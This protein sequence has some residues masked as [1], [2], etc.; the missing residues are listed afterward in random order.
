[1]KAEDWVRLGEHLKANADLLEAMALADET[2]ITPPERMT[3][4][5][6]WLMSKG[7]VEEDSDLLHLS[8]LLLDVGAQISIQGFDRVAPDLKEILISIEEG[9]EAYHGAKAA[10]DPAETERHLRRVTNT[11]RQVVQ[12]LRNEQNVTRAFIEGGYGF[13]VRLTDRIRDI[14]NA[15][16]RLKRLHEKLGLFTHTGLLQL[17]RSDRALRGKLIDGLLGAVSRNRFALDEMIGRLDRLSLTVRKRNKMRQVAQAV[18]AHLQGGGVIDLEPLLERLDAAVWAGAAPLSLGGNAFCDVHAGENLEQL[19][20]LIASLPAP[21]VKAASAAAAQER[22]SKIVPSGANQ[23]K[24]LEKPF[25]RAHLEA[26][27]RELIATGK[28]Q[29]A[30][31][32]WQDCGDPDIPDGIWLYALD[33]YAQLQAAFAKAN[34]KKLNY[35]LVLTMAPH[36]RFSANR[37][38]L[39]LTLDRVLRR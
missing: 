20:L 29:S 5:L 22:E 12:H 32:Y 21:K 9:C 31:A 28:P 34:G 35:R 16:D 39:E 13:S 37:R 7:L 10:G 30:T 4:G 11:T 6:S 15:I 18:D 33:G 17:T 25:V 26:M 23:E 38:V 36:S 19:E 14:K 24:E 27:L 3:K 8:G 1:M 2:G